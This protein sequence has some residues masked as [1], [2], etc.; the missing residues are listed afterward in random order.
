[1]GFEIIVAYFHGR[2]W[3]TARQQRVAQV[4]VHLGIVRFY[5]DRALICSYRSVELAGSL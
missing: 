1:M 4:C 3:I 5:L 2:A